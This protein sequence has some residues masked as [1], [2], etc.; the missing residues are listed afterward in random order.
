MARNCIAASRAIL[1]TLTIL[2]A[3]S[4]VM[5]YFFF[6][7]ANCTT[8]QALP[9][10]LYKGMFGLTHIPA[11]FANGGAALFLKYMRRIG[12]IIIF[13]TLCANFIAIS[14]GLL[15][16]IMMDKT[17]LL[18]VHFYL[19][20]NHRQCPSYAVLTSCCLEILHSALDVVVVP[21]GLHAGPLRDD[22]VAQGRVL[23][24]AP[25]FA[26][27]FVAEIIPVRSSDPRQFLVGTDLSQSLYG[28]ERRQPCNGSDVCRV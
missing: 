15:P 23:Y 21:N 12:K 13:P 3:A 22:A 5:G 27:R 20:M 25:R 11:F 18:R 9:L 16:L 8:L 1:L 2:R 24:E 10:N 6:L 28:T 7:A 19:L 26:L 14:C 17:Y 4:H